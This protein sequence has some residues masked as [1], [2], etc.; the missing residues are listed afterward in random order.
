MSTPGAF[1][2]R[3][4]GRTRKDEYGTCVKKGQTKSSQRRKALVEI[5]STPPSREGRAASCRRMEL[6]IFFFFL[7]DGS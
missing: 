2:P 5:L 6:V 1:L 7:T 4:S 3:L